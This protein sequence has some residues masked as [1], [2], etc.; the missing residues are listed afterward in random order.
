MEIAMTISHS[1]NETCGRASPMSA[2]LPTR[3]FETLRMAIIE[4]AARLFARIQYRW[5]MRRFARFSTHRLQDI[6]FERDWDGSII[7]SNNR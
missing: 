5:T 6:G 2:L 7:D 1:Y 3:A 4:P